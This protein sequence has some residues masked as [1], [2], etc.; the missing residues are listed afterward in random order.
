MKSGEQ[1]STAHESRQGRNHRHER[2]ATMAKIDAVLRVMAGESMESLSREL[3]VSIQRIDRWK[4]TFIEGGSSELSKKTDAQ[5]ESWASK[6]ASSIWQ[7]LWLLLA[8]LV[9]ITLL[10]LYLGRSSPG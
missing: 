8:M 7:W 2:I 9:V 4:N 1:P 5:S 3:N 10:V 6:H